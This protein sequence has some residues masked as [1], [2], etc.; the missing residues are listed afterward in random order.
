MSIASTC[1]DFIGA[2]QRTIRHLSLTLSGDYSTGGDTLDLTATTNPNRIPAAK[3]FS[4]LPD[5]ISLEN[6]PGG[7]T[8]ELIP[9][10]ALNNNLLKIYTAEGTELAAAVYPAAISG[11]T[12]IVVKVVSK[13][14]V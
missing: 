8:F 10:T 3:A 9:G 2:R 7:Y 5:V 12:D 11:A 13:T 4:A 1:I 6:F 14:N